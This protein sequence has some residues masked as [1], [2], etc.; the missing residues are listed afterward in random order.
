MVIQQSASEISF[1]VEYMY[2]AYDIV[3]LFHC[4]CYS[5]L[6][7]SVLS[8]QSLYSVPLLLI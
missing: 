6:Q 4:Y 3:M 7:D 8:K 2:V 5:L 1:Y